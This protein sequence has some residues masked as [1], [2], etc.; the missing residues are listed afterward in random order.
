MDTNAL[1]GL[2]RSACAVGC[3]AGTI[4]TRQCRREKPDPATKPARSAAYRS[5]RGSTEA[6]SD[7][8]ATVSVRY[9]VD[10]V[11]DAIAFYCGRLGFHEDMHPAPTF[12]M[13]SR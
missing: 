3:A 6:R 11:D 7:A 13:L 9:I 5:H 12:A 1:D 2:G 10:D 4:A 8:M